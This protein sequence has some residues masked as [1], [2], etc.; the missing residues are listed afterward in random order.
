MVA[1]ATARLVRLTLRLNV[2]KALFLVDIP[3]PESVEIL[4]EDIPVEY[5]S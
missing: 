5:T 1:F 4:P 3:E 2:D